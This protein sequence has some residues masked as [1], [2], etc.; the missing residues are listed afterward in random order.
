[1]ALFSKWKNRVKIRRV[2]MNV[3]RLQ[4][5]ILQNVKNNPERSLGLRRLKECELFLMEA[6][7]R[8]GE[9]R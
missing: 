8:Q 5:W 3:L 9:S 4:E 2:S 7:S 1:M 6:I